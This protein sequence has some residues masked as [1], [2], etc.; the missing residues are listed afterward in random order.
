[1]KEMAGMSSALPI[2]SMTVLFRFSTI[3]RQTRNVRAG[4][5]FGRRQGDN[6]RV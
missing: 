3:V 5:S 2:V 1:M 6:S 4:N